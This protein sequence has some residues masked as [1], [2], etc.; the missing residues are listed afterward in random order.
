MHVKHIGNPVVTAN[1]ISVIKVEDLLQQQIKLDFPE[2]QRKERSEMSGGSQ[3]SGKCQ[4][5]QISGWT[6]LY[7]TAIKE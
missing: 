2:H 4:N 3:V 1:R 5:C 7:W 6:L